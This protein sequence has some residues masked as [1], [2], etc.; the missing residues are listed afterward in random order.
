VVPVLPLHGFDSPEL[1]DALKKMRQEGYTLA[2]DTQGE[3]L[4]Q[5]P[6]LD[7]V[8]IV[9][10]DLR[11]P[12][13]DTLHKIAPGLLAAELTLMAKRV[14]TQ[15]A[16]GLAKKLGC[17][18]FS[19]YFF[20][21][22]ETVS[23]RKISAVETTRLALLNLLAQPEPDTDELV[24]TIEADASVS[25]RV[26]ALLNSAS[27]SLPKK[28]ASV[29]QAVLMAGWVNLCS[30]LRV[31]VLADMAPS[32]KAREVLHLSAQRAKFFEILAISSGRQ[33]QADSL[34]LLG[35]FSLL[36]SMLDLPMPNLVER[37]GLEDSLAEG[38]CGKPGPYALW[39]ALALAIEHTQWDEMGELVAQLGLPT[40]SVADAYNESF[41]WADK[42][43]SAMPNGKAKK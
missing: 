34:F 15:A 35:L 16:Y 32:T 30:W 13:V 21:E 17:T 7:L 18:L 31:I 36:P 28:V 2:L 38:L 41:T 1:L 26:L 5:S 27:F 33:S 6:L 25:Y 43:I 12:A 24:A 37:L 22:P 42:L 14:E 23:Q 29:R 19:G 10:L 9:I 39:L 3:E 20:R 4:G 8:D 11:G 40:G